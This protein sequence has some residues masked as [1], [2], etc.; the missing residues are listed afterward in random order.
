[1]RFILE[2]QRLSSFVFVEHEALLF[3]SLEQN[4]GRQHWVSN[5]RI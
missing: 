5:K 4:R 1:M 3:L 2:L